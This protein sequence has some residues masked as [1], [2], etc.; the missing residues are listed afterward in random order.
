MRQPFEPPDAVLAVAAESVGGREPKGRGRRDRRSPPSLEICQ[1][2]KIQCVREIAILPDRTCRYTTIHGREGWVSGPGVRAGASGPSA[3]PRGTSGPSAW[4]WR[5][6]WS[7]LDTDSSQSARQARQAV[8][9]GVEGV[10]FR[11]TTTWPSAW[12]WRGGVASGPPVQRDHSSA[13][14]A[15][16]SS[17]RYCGRPLWSLNWS[18]RSMP[19]TR[20][21]VARTF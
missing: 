16:R 21:R 12:R 14:I 17:R 9:G 2:V 8:G 5:G 1:V 19:S 11:Y 13:S 18:S 10:Q 3:W 4:G 6:Y 15:S 20:Y 7:I